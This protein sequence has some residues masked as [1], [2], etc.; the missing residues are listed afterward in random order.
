MTNVNQYGWKALIGSAV[1]YAM[2]GFDLLILGFMLSAISADLNLTPAQSGSLVTWTLVGAVVGGIVFGALSD[3]Y[4][5]VRVLTW[6]IVLFA[7]FTGLCAI[8]QGYWD[9]L[10]YRTIAG[11]GLGGEFGIGMAL[12][13]EAWPAKHRAKAASYVALGW[14]FGVLAAALLTPVLLPHIGWRGMF[15]VGIFPTFVAWYLRV[16]LHEPEIFSQK[17]TALSTQKISKLESF[18]LL[19]K[20]KATTKVSLGVV[21]LT[22]VQ[23]FGYYGIMIWMPNFLSKQLGFSLTKSGLWTAVTVCGMMAG[24]WIFGRLADRIGRKPS[25]LLFQLG[26]V[27]SIITYSQL[28]DQTAMLVAGAFLGMFVNGMMGGYGALMAEA[29]PT[30]ARA[31]AQN[32]L[33]N[34]GRAVGGFGPVVVGA[35]VS[36]YSFSIAIAFLAVIYVIDMVATVFLVPELKGKELS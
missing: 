1:G 12:A 31:T 28:T 25:F 6:T 30:E 24:I 21:V 17:Q 16:R 19:V 26:A 32:V 7:V 20:D 10:I 34:L 9:L 5:R 22:S 2:D 35:V 8:A 27:I 33:F 36:A 11:I 4:G 23:N 29:Y 14:Q 3:R 13:I 18:K 15:V